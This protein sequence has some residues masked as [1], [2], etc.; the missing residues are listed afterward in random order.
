MTFGD[1]I[2]AFY[3]GGASLA[4][5]NHCRIL[6]AQKKVNGLSIASTVFFTSWGFWNMYYYNSLGQTF[7][8]AAGFAVCFANCYYVSLLLKYKDK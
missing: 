7:S 8:W 6:N 4:V 5:L 1:L 3:E 2:N